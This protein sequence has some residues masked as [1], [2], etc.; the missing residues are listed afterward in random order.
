MRIAAAG[1]KQTRSHSVT[2]AMPAPSKRVCQ[3]LLRFA[4]DG[5]GPAASARPALPQCAR[6]DID[7]ILI[8]RILH[9]RPP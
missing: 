7:R 6:R 3:N 5:I 9:E 1:G 2:S 8:G 4:A